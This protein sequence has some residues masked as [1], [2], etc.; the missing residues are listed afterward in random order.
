MNSIG[1]RVGDIVGFGVDAHFKEEI[2]SYCKRHNM[3]PK[4]LV[5]DITTG[6]ENQLI[7]TLGAN[8]H[9]LIVPKRRFTFTIKMSEAQ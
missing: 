6:K 1:Q 9:R 4:D 2:T 8:D 3:Q 5:I 7:L